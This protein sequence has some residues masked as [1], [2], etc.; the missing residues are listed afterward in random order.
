MENFGKIVFRGHEILA[1]LKSKIYAGDLT[2]WCKHLP[3]KH[4]SLIP[5]TSKYI[6]K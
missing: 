4:K 3:A 5:S 2:Q 6:N 1:S